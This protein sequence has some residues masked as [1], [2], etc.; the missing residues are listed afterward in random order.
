M[1]PAELVRCRRTRPEPEQVLAE[2]ADLDKAVDSTDALIAAAEP[3]SC[4]R[5][6][7]W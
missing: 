1:K 4:Q 2:A 6:R 7:S 3:G 5:N